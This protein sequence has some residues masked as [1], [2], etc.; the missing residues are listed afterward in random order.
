MIIFK[1][2]A[3][4]KTLSRSTLSH[5]SHPQWVG[6]PPPLQDTYLFW[7]DRPQ[8]LRDADHDV[9]YVSNVS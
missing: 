4:D 7:L 1:I 3:S 6:K 5:A 9:L 2:E 8:L